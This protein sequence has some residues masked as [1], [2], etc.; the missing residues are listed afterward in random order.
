V[1]FRFAIGTEVLPAAELDALIA[2]ADDSA[3]IA[4]EMRKAALF[5]QPSGGTKASVMLDELARHAEKV[6]VAHIQSLLTGLFEVA[7]EINAEA[8][9]NRHFDGMTNE[10]R[11]FLLSHCLTR[12]R[13]TL[14]KKS[15]IY[16]AACQTAS[17]GWLASFVA[18]MT[19]ELTTFPD[20][21]ELWKLLA[22]RI[23]EASKDGSLIR[24]KNL[25]HLL[26]CWSKLAGD[27]GVTIKQWAVPQLVDDEAVKQFAVAFTSYGSSQK[28]GTNGLG[29]R[30]AMP[31]IRVQVE[32]LDRMIGVVAFRRRVEEVAAKGTCREV[33]KFL[34]AWQRREQGLD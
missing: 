14:E 15:E 3:F 27:D 23:A 34:Q 19:W 16:V 20:F 25:A 5:A 26:Y 29:D 7:D 13:L 12:E 8:D 30:V 6:D 18:A 31:T 32:E 2:K 28:L 10:R 4:A 9:R 11:L 17:L 24:N 22:D 1:Y 33:A 21:E